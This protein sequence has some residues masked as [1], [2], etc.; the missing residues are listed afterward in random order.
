M[1]CLIPKE[2]DMSYTIE[3]ERLWNKGTKGFSTRGV[4]LKSQNWN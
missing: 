1:K 4:L 3:N 2:A